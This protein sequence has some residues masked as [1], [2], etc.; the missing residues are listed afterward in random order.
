[1]F[2]SEWKPLFLSPAGSRAI[3]ETAFLNLELSFLNV[4]F[5]I[6]DKTLHW[7]LII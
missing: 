6:Y 2:L 4:K 7:G 5:N 3:T 1:M